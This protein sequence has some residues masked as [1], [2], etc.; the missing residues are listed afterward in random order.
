MSSL[1]ITGQFD[2]QGR[3][4]QFRTPVEVAQLGNTLR[5]KFDGNVWAVKDD[6]GDWVSP[7]LHRIGVK[8]KMQVEESP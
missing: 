4:V 3:L 8:S 6:Y 7:N 1:R 2:T 5:D